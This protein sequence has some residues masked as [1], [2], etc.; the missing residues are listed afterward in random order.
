M[1]CAV[2]H[3][4][5]YPNG[6]SGRV[7]LFDVP[8]TVAGAPINERLV[9]A[10]SIDPGV[11]DGAGSQFG[12]AVAAA[13]GR[14]VASARQGDNPGRTGTDDGRIYVLDTAGAFRSAWG[15]DDGTF[16]ELTRNGALAADGGYAVIG[17]ARADGDHGKAWLVPLPRGVSPSSGTYTRWRDHLPA[18]GVVAR[19]RRVPTAASRRPVSCR[20]Q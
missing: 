5:P 19:R 8:T 7:Y 11:A 15:P 1:R 6:G 18:A 3:H 14:I 17:D 9:L 12:A 10:S 20:R 13:G 16:F 2:A 4:R